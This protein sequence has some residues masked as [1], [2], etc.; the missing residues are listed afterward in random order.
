MAWTKKKIYELTAHAS[1]VDSDVLPI[2]LTASWDAG[3]ATALELKTYVAAW[4]MSASTYDPATIAEQVVGLT[5]TQNVSNKTLIAPV[6]ST[7][8]NTGTLTLPTSTD[9]L[10]GKATTDVMTNKGFDAN[11]TGNSISNIDIAD[12][13]N[14]TDWELITWDAAWAPAAVAVG[15]ATHVLTSNWVWAAPTFQASAAG[16]TDPM[17]TRGDVIYKNASN[18]TT[19]LPIW[20]AGT[21]L[22][23]DGTDLSYSTPAGSWDV[24]KVGTPVNSQIWVWT[25]DGT[26]EWATSLTYDGSNL[27]LTWDIGSTLTR[28]TKGRYTDLQV[29][30]AIAGS[31][32]GNAATVTTITGLAPDTA[33]TQATQAS[34]TTA[35]NLTTVG[36]VTTGNVDAVVSASSTTTAGKIEV[37]TVAETDTG[38]DAARAV[39]PDGLAWSYAGTKSA[40]VYTIDALTDLAVADG[41]AYITIPAALNGMNLVTVAANVITA[42]TTGVSTIQVHNVTWAVNMLSTAMTIDSAETSTSTAATPPVIDTANDDVATGDVIRID[43]DAISTTAPKWLIVNLEFR[44]P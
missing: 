30:N 7:I 4:D 12:L 37:A 44:L 38:T 5:A 40:S 24:V 1:V 23:S 31:I 10:M 2:S 17:T 19:R 25:W 35:A 20:W 26:I 28:I 33:T 34:I 16:F 3:K 29:T 22:W 36:T 27:Q 15:T 43:I 11:G 32:T 41:N 14:G 39:S 18:T 9:T 13:A 21:F 6:I 42:G 8:S